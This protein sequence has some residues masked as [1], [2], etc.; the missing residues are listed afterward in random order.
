MMVDDK[1]IENRQCK[2]YNIPIAVDDNKSKT[3][4]SIENRKCKDY[5]IPIESRS[6][7]DYDIPIENRECKDYDIPITNRECQDYDIP[8]EKKNND[9]NQNTASIIENR[10]CKD[11]DISL[12]GKTTNTAGH[13]TVTSNNSDAHK[14]SVIAKDEIA[15]RVVKE[16]VTRDQIEDEI[17]SFLQA[18]F[19]WKN[20]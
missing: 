13:V 18:P 5:D 9:E 1:T 14:S 2:D 17:Q 16:G 3:P 15:S 12:E 20:E 8:I 11:Y 4:E 10:K 6:C 19:C 7:K